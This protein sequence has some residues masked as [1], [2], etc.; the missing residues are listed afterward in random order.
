MVLCWPYPGSIRCLC[1]GRAM[2]SPP[3]L[4]MLV[5]LVCCCSTSSLFSADIAPVSAAVPLHPLLLCVSCSMAL[6]QKLRQWPWRSSLT[7]WMHPW[8]VWQAL[9]SPHPTQLTW[10]RW[11]SPKGKT[12]SMKSSGHWA[13][14][15]QGWDQ[16]SVFG[17]LVRCRSW[18]RF[19]GIWGWRPVQRAATCCA[20][21]CEARTVFA[22]LLSSQLFVD[23]AQRCSG[24]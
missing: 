14:R 7:S 20:A 9:R 16:A 4:H 6:V 22:V 3:P 19:L 21:T 17:G 1:W 5:L 12:S 23:R 15:D 18:N 13:G 2:H 24:S 8:G 10:R 11:F